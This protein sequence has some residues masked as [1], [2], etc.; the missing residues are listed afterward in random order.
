[1]QWLGTREN[2]QA[3]CRSGWRQSQF[4]P[5]ELSKW[6]KFCLRNPLA[7]QTP[8]LIEGRVV[9]WDRLELTPQMFPIFSVS[10]QIYRK[11]SVISSVYSPRLLQP[12]IP[13]ITSPI[14][15]TA[16]PHSVYS[17]PTPN[18]GIN[19]VNRCDKR[20]MLTT[21]GRGLY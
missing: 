16:P 1:M 17:P 2:F 7:M 12:P 10:Y 13:P 4:Q 19:F 21:R 15:F 14:P 3:E 6:R 18:Y 9:H 20:I 8:V 11:K 5:K